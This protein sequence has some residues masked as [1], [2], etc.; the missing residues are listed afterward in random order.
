[1]PQR[2]IL[3]RV[4]AVSYSRLSVSSPPPAT[5][6]PPPATVL[7]P[8]SHTRQGSSS[9]GSLFCS[10]RLQSSTG[11]VDWQLISYL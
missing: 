1:M 4:Q 5:V 7:C 3:D 2:L 10:L 11:H 6:D 9:L 8:P